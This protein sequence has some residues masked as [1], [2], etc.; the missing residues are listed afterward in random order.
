MIDQDKSLEQ[1]VIGAD[2]PTTTT[3]PSQQTSGEKEAKL[4][5]FERKRD[6]FMD[7]AK[8]HFLNDKQKSL[9]LSKFFDIR[10][11]DYLNSIDIK[12]PDLQSK[13]RDKWV[14]NTLTNISIPEKKKAEGTTETASD[15]GK[16]S[17]DIPLE[18]QSETL[19]SLYNKRD[20]LKSKRG[21]GKIARAEYTPE[22]SRKLELLNEEIEGKETE[23]QYASPLGQEIAGHIKAM[24]VEELYLTDKPFTEYKKELLNN[25]GGK[26]ERVVDYAIGMSQQG[27]NDY[28]YSNGL[29]MIDDKTTI[30]DMAVE[31]GKKLLSSDKDE[32]K[33]I[34]L[35]ENIRQFINNPEKEGEI[36]EWKKELKDLGFDPEGW[37]NYKTGYRN[38][39]GVY[40][41]SLIHI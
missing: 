33:A 30:P 18:E 8:F 39:E 36:K 34:E 2:A 5:D 25:Y 38:K 21:S 35:V 15:T 29:N 4:L 32:A 22:D 20:A 14:A 6:E 24:P 19:D 3:A 7:N 37:M 23:Q 13:L 31:K 16:S 9:A 26:S 41:L 1:E 12:D 11:T 10:G 40:E 28:Y 17:G 27:K